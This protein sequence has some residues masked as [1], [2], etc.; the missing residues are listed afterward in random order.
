[1]TA[2]GIAGQGR[3]WRSPATAASRC[4][5]GAVEPQLN[6][7]NVHDPAALAAAIGT[8]LESISPRP[9]RVALVLPDTVAQGLADAVREGPGK[10]SRISI[11]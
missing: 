4:P 8:A 1:M 3:D 10:A 5:T 7:V 6:G 9:R 2:V 11:S